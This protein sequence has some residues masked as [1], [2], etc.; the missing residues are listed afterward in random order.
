MSFEYQELFHSQDS[1]LGD[2]KK[3]GSLSAKSHFQTLFQLEEFW[4]LNYWAI[5]TFKGIVV[6]YIPSTLGD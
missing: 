1:S 6:A 2:R 5:Y 4:A 3:Y